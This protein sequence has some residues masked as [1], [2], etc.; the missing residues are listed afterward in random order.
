M[1]TYAKRGGSSWNAPGGGT[2][3]PT[4][5]FREMYSY[6]TAGQVT[7]KRLKVS[8]LYSGA[9]AV[10]TDFLESSYTF[11]NEGRMTRHIYPAAQVGGAEVGGT[12]LNYGFDAMG[13]LNTL[14]SPGLIS[15]VTYNAAG[16]PTA[17]NSA[18]PLVN[19]ETRVYNVLGQ[20]TSLTNGLRFEYD[21]PAT[22]NDGRI[23][24]QRTYSASN[25]LVETN[26]YN[27]D[28]LSR[29][30]AASGGGWNATYGY[31]GFTNLLTVAGTGPSLMNI[32]VNPTNNRVNGW[33]YEANGNVTQQGSFSGSYDV[34]NRLSEA[35]KN[36]AVRYGYRADNR[37]IYESKRGTENAGGDT[38][39]EFVTYWDAGRRMCLYKMVW[40][41]TPNSFV[42]AKAEENL[43]FGPKALRLGPITGYDWPLAVDRLGSIRRGSGKDHF[44]YGQENPS[45]TAGDKEKYATYRHA[46]ATDLSYAD[47]RYYATGTGRFMTADPAGDGLN[48][49]AYVGG[50]PVNGSDPRGERIE[51]LLGG[52]AACA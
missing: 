34:E 1:E 9:Y 31:D 30:T 22:G 46:A 13:R 10:A 7:G 47:Q 3:W 15:G 24:A 50:D 12:D 8:G 11:D 21:F 29:L 33:T 14:L 45:T 20:M 23:T 43:Y 17:I 5:T 18:H 37:R 26:T 2:N 39:E 19:S 16:Q 51:W 28:S 49:Y 32:T 52:A 27:Y 6:S 41:T 40:A 38:I 48:W 4:M 25:T 42:F 35:S 36:G 44:P